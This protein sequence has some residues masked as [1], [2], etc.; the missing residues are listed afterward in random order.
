M[1]LT[2][3]VYEVRKLTTHGAVPPSAYM[4]DFMAWCLSKRRDKLT[5]LSFIKLDHKRNSDVR[6]RLKVTVVDEEQQR[7][8]QNKIKKT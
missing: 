3:N 6:E 1:V 5:F 7:Y 2:I 4:H 8:Q